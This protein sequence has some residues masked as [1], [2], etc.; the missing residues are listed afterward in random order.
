MNIGARLKKVNPDWLH[1][2]LRDRSPIYRKHEWSHKWLYPAWL[3]YK[4]LPEPR[5]ISARVEASTIRSRDRNRFL[6]RLPAAAG[7][8]DQVITCFTE[9]YLLAKQYDLRF[10]F[11][12]F[13]G[14]EHTNV[15]W[16]AFLGFGDGEIALDTVMRR[17]GLQ[18][19]YIPPVPL[20]EAWGNRC[21]ASIVTR[22]YPG[23]NILFHLGT[24][25]YLNA[26]AGQADVMPD[27]YRRKY[28]AAP[29]RGLSP[30]GAHRAASK[31]SV[32]IHVRRGDVTPRHP[33]SAIRWVPNAFYVRALKTL[34]EGMDRNDLE[35]A[36]YTDGERR[37]VDEIAD[38]SPM[39]VHAGDDPR[40][41]FHQLVESQFLL[42]GTSSFSILA[43]KLSCGMKLYPGGAE[44]PNFRLHIPATDDWIAVDRDGHIPLRGRALVTGKYDQFRQMRNDLAAE[45]I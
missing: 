35:I 27:I 18:V 13:V 38:I 5:A 4:L 37:Q 33:Q 17:T 2:T 45:Q 43:G 30:R 24:G 15:D 21:L 28:W 19:V 16:N 34:L 6:T 31:L 8:G 11:A 26:E 3:R 12:P 22:L 41:T 25:V 20:N 42:L 32:G 36:L 7:I 29:A 10:A 1:R 39:T 9:T 14:S 23:P 40:I 44:G